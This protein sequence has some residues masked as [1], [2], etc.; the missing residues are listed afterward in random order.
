M[1][2]AKI[3]ATDD[4]KLKAQINL[5]TSMKITEK[6]KDLLIRGRFSQNRKLLFIGTSQEPGSKQMGAGRRTTAEK[7]KVYKGI[8][9]N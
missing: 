4:K 8:A 6:L 5:H 7:N 3:L 2:H 9:R 1:N